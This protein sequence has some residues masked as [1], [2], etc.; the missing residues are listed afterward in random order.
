MAHPLAKKLE[1][2]LKAAILGGVARLLPRRVLAVPDW[3]ARPWRVLYLRYD[4]IGDMIMSTALIRAVARSHPTIEL[5]VLASP[6]NAPVLIDNPHVRSVLV[7]NRRSK[8]GLF[9]VWNELRRR[10]YDVVIDGGVTAPSVTTMLL[11][12]AAGAPYRI[13]LSGRTNDAIYTL[14]VPAGAPDASFLV[15]SLRTAQPFGVTLEGADRHPDLFITADERQRAEARW[16]GEP[17]SLRLLVNVSA[18]T[19]DRRWPHDR[20]AVLVAWLR[21]AEPDARILVT[22]DPGDWAAVQRVAAGH[23]EPVNVSPVREVFALVGAADAL[24]TPD[25]SLSHA[26][27]A[28]GTP[29]AV[30]FRADWLNHK[31]ES[32]NLVPVVSDGSTLS[33]LPLERAIQAMDPLLAHARAARGRRLAAAGRSGPAPV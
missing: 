9:R 15:E 23:A 30:F 2:A 26:A 25:T 10:R 16:G 21:R 32:A 20:S 17:G 29:F 14:P 31:P 11:M 8:T 4:R 24:V 28:L 13:G 3:R 1:R 19:A 12:V 18:F 22:G 6:S 27:A 5:D 33:E 7:F